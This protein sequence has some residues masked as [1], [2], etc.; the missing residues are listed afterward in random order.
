MQYAY[1]AYQETL[2]TIKPVR[3][4]VFSMTW[5]PIFPSATKYADENAMGIK[6]EKTL[7]VMLASPFWRGEENDKLITDAAETLIQK[8]EQRA[9]E[10]GVWHPFKYANYS[11]QQQ[12]PYGGYAPGRRDMLRKVSKAYDPEGVFQAS[13]SPRASPAIFHWSVYTAPNANELRR[14]RVFRADSRFEL[15]GPAST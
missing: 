9:K 6:T 15:R 12:D 13:P 11:S 3:R 8:V 1:V 2:R 10:L 5:Q 14:R 4:I 7:T